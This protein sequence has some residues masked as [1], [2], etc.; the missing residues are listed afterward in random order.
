MRSAYKYLA[1]LVCVL[2]MVQA[3]SHAF[4]SAGIAKFL[5]NG[6]TIDVNSTELPDFPEAVGLMIHGINGMM[7]IPLVALVLLVVSFLTR[8][9]GA[10]VR[11]AVVFVLVVVQVTLG[12]GGHSITVLA[13]LHGIN[14]LLVFGA[15][16]VAARFMGKA[17]RETVAAPTHAAAGV[18]VG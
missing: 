6:G 15:A 10:V 16:F 17:S 11:A 3:S 9:R 5:E 18:P 2:V 12:L 7:V 13:L 8:T 14:A 4:A 1:Y